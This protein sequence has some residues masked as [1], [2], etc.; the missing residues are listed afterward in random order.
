MFQFCKSKLIKLRNPNMCIFCPYAKVP[1]SSC[2]LNH[3]LWVSHCVGRPQGPAGVFGGVWVSMQS[4]S[5]AAL[6]YWPAAHLLPINSSKSSVLSL[7]LTVKQP[8]GS[9]FIFLLV[10]PF[11]ISLSYVQR[12]HRG[13]FQFLR[14]HF[15]FRTKWLLML[16]RG[17]LV[18]PCPN[19]ISASIRQHPT[20][21][22]YVMTRWPIRKC[23]MLNAFYRRGM[24][25]RMFVK[26]VTFW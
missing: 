18:T 9:V 25:A 11:F 14:S 5:E 13:R 15:L 16:Y 19:R 8:F 6:Q 10:T 3:L 1:Q 7:S 4:V 21:N 12:L 2:K 24:V 20:P 22:C 17:T 23:L 26:S